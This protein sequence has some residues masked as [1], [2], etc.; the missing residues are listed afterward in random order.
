MADETGKEN[1]METQEVPVD[2]LK[3]PEE[4]GS[5]ASILEK[6]PHPV[7]TGHPAAAAEEEET[8]PGPGEEATPPEV[9]PKGEEKPPEPPEPPEFK[10]KY[11]NQEEAERAHQEAERRMHEATTQAAQEKEAREAAERERD[12]LK[13]KLAEKETTKPPEPPAKTQEE[14]DAEREAKIEA[15]LDEIEQ[16]DTS[17]PDYRKKVAKAWAK[18][19]FGGGGQPAIPGSKELEEMVGRLVADR[20]QER[21]AADAAQRQKDEEDRQARENA[22]LRTKAEDL[23]TQAGLNMGKGTVDYRLFWDVAG[24][25]SDEVKAKPFAEQVNWTVGEVRRLKG[26]V[27]Q[28][29]DQARQRGQENQKNNS[30]LEKGANRP[31]TPPAPEPYTLGSIMNKHQE[32]RRI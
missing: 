25:I 7:F 4:E 30:V 1:V 20:L 2:E 27:V 17:A 29:T 9:T 11:K 6:A 12:G 28:T 21:E 19:G 26:E 16:L 32:A 3:G 18:A 22:N 13:A 14:L 23:A 5:L 10:P 15:A 31:H 24:E 8:P